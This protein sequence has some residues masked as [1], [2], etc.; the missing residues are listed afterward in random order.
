MEES[1]RKIKGEVIVENVEIMI[2]KEIQEGNQRKNSSEN[3][4]ENKYEDDERER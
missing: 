1:G 2:E 3:E 4:R